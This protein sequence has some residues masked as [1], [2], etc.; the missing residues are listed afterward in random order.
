VAHAEA[1]AR[2]V[3]AAV[4]AAAA[5]LGLSPDQIDVE[6]LEDPVPSTFGY[7][8][9]PARVRVTPRQHASPS[10]DVR[11]GALGSPPGVPG[12]AAASGSSDAPPVASTGQPSGG[13]GV[14][15]PDQPSA[16]PGVDA[17]RQSSD[18]PGVAAAGS[19]GSSPGVVAARQPSDVPGEAASSQ[20]SDA[21]QVAVPAEPPGLGQG[22]RPETS[23]SGPAAGPVQVPRPDERS[24]LGEVSGPEVVSDPGQV[25]G[26]GEAS[27]DARASGSGQVSGSAAASGPAQPSGPG[28][29][30]PAQASPPATSDLGQAPGP[31]QDTGATHVSERS[32]ASGSPIADPATYGPKPTSLPIPSDTPNSSEAAIEPAT[33][34][35]VIPGRPPDPS[36]D[37]TPDPAH[38]SAP[39]G[40]GSGEARG[41]S[42]PAT[43]QAPPP[44]APS[45][46]SSSTAG[47]DDPGHTGGAVVPDDSD[48]TRSGM[49]RETI[50]QSPTSTRSLT[51]A[52]EET[53]PSGPNPEGASGASTAATAPAV[54]DV[55]PPLSVSEGSSATRP[56]RSYRDEP[57]DPEIVEAD[58]ERAGDFLEGLLDALDV[59]GDIT[60]WV[61]EA[62]GHVDLE[63]SDLNVLVGSNGE[64]LDALQEL[65]RIAVL[66][67][68]KRRVRLLLDINGF[69]SRQRDQLVSVVKATAERVIRSREEHEFQPMT[70]AERKIVHD[71]AAAI[72]GV[73]TE[74]LGEEPYRRVVLRP[75]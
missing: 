23:G 59:D 56:R 10:G 21:S 64:T 62:G 61:D 11:D 48:S 9:S 66:R 36:H 69:R 43:T 27:G 46:P 5:Q 2:T 73:Q 17:E 60:T 28:Q 32:P 4:T 20:S 7:I 24:G 13:P 68:S 75:T 58:T 41:P 33:S 18:A 71:A 53:P 74:S 34:P 8:G 22:D 3:E 14:A 38:D 49:Q 57:I 67:Q 44:T 51:D 6:V 19:P 39:S 16:V 37:T 25:A 35:A 52:D 54:D 31:A 63:G 55:P 26:S 65:T 47:Q 30:H 42:G 1:S 50:D 72:D 45:S 29:A 70:P 12:A 15:G 40:S